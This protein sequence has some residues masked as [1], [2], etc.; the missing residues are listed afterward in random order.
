MWVRER[1]RARD[2][3]NVCTDRWWDVSS[4]FTEISVIEHTVTAYA[5]AHVWHHLGHR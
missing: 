5:H 4:L 3:V 1:E 2:Y